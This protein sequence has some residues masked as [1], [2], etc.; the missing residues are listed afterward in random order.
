M[1]KITL[2]GI[3]ICFALMGWSQN[4]TPDESIT[5]PG[6]Y[7]SFLDTAV[8]GASYTHTLQI[9]AIKD[10]MVTI[11]NQEVTADVDSVVLE[12]ILGLPTNFTYAC[13]PPRCTFT[14]QSVGC[15]QL[16][17]M[18]TADQIGEYPLEIVI[19]SHARLGSVLFPTK[20]TIRDF[21]LVVQDSNLSSLGPAQIAG[22][23]IFP[24]PNKG[25]LVHIE[26][27]IACSEYS[28]M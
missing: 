3:Y 13:E 24:N 17:G 28:L 21:T 18:P 26:S 2:L 9:L 23:K 25:H 12:E 16:S 6:I 14:W 4:C 8:V 20:D 27:S 10:T 1:K 19:T 11:A 15:A 5:D 22:F 7:P